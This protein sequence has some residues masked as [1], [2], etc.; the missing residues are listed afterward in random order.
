LIL[1]LMSSSLVNP[2]SSSSP[3][4]SSLSSGPF[5][6]ADKID[7]GSHKYN[8]HP[9]TMN[10]CEQSQLN[11]L[12]QRAR[13]KASM[14]TP[15]LTETVTSMNENDTSPQ[16]YSSLTPTNLLK[17]GE[18]FLL[19][20]RSFKR[21]SS[22]R[23]S[24]SKQTEE[25]SF[26]NEP[27]DE[28][29]SPNL[30]VGTV[31]ERLRNKILRKSS[32]YLQM[33]DE[34]TPDNSAIIVNEN[35]QPSSST[36]DKTTPP[37]SIRSGT[38]AK[39]SKLMNDDSFGA[40]EKKQRGRSSSHQKEEWNK[41]NYVN[42][43]I[44][45]DSIEDLSINMDAT[46]PDQFDKEIET[47]PLSHR[48]NN[49]EA[50]LSHRDSHRARS[51]NNNN[52]LEA[53]QQQPNN[54]QEEQQNELFPREVLPEVEAKLYLERCVG[55]FLAGMILSVCLMLFVTREDQKN[56]FLQGA[57]LV[58][59]A[60]LFYNI[61]ENI[62]RF[63]MTEREN[64]RRSEDIL[65]AIDSFVKIFFM[66]SIHLEVI[67]LV[68]FN[69]F[70]FLVFC[71]N[72]AAYHFKSEAPAKIKAMRFYVK[73]LY[74]F[75]A[76]ILS[77]KLHGEIEW[78]WVY[79]FSVSW[80]FFGFVGVYLI[81]YTA[82]FILSCLFLLIQVLFRRSAQQQNGQ[83]K[84]QTMGIL[85]SS[86]YYGLGASTFLALIG[87]NKAYSL[88]G[89]VDLLKLALMSSVGLNAVLFLYTCFAFKYLAKYIQYYSLTDDSLLGTDEEENNE[90]AKE[91]ERKFLVF[92]KSRY[93]EMLSSTYFK[94]I[95]KNLLEKNEERLGEIKQMLSTF[96]KQKKRN[97]RSK[98]FPISSP[99]E[100]KQDKENLDKKLNDVI[101]KGRKNL[102]SEVKL[103]LGNLEAVSPRKTQL[104]LDRTRSNSM[105]KK[106]HLSVDD[107]QDFKEWNQKRLDLCLEVQ[108]DN[109]CYLCCANTADAL[110]MG[111]GHGGICYEC[112]MEIVSKSNQCM[113]CRQTVDE[114]CKIDPKT[115]VSG[116]IKTIEVCK[117]SR[118]AV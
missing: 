101:Q 10:S 63:K 75:Q 88:N 76:L 32:S 36:L 91:S 34:L 43:S 7:G 86:L 44:D 100:L 64:W 28:C 31:K 93:F 46:N 87:S 92:K 4:Q 5:H 25:L 89:S 83:M 68:P 82:V 24:F 48:N 90:E 118:A 103:K 113:Q 70:T 54:Q 59:Y 98:D 2:T 42:F 80:L 104:T 49:G 65:D 13:N 8:S 50:A 55:S 19:R 56:Q 18:R 73:L 9:H 108:E 61:I 30:L 117:I 115:Q 78:S 22:E 21:F 105:G 85:W 99:E 69:L 74:A 29:D 15:K 58:S 62:K 66:M 102:L 107:C 47:M 27:L 40:K 67:D 45:E 41:V 20:N 96:V 106:G 33:E 111:C 26:S 110:L 77:L 11:F 35:K 38:E 17:G 97:S 109:N 57:F 72:A 52:D 94:P 60:Y 51:G 53:Q 1:I 71:F 6:Q 12:L 112:A 114:V 16:S 81:A 84:I 116:F 37:L 95:N 23:V 3:H 39:I 14:I 79:V